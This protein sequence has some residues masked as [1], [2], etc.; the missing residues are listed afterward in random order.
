MPPGEREWLADRQ[1]GVRAMAVLGHSQALPAPNFTTLPFQKRFPSHR[2]S[3]TF[4]SVL[5]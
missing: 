1:A 5:G 2:V 3:G 4:W